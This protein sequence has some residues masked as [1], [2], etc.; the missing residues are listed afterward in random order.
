MVTIK[1][2]VLLSLA[3][4]L[5][6]SAAQ[7]AQEWKAGICPVMKGKTSPD[8][9]YEY[10]G[11]MYYFCCPGCIDAFKKDPRKYV[12]K[13]KEI[14]VTAKQYEFVPAKI[15]VKEGDIVRLTL[16]TADVRHGLMIHGYDVNIVVD[17]GESKTVE[18]LADKKGTF[19]FHCSV[20]C[21][22]GHKRMHGDLLVE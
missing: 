7:A 10:Q 21:G 5:L 9:S 6:V 15:T 11:K 14:A 12:S 4:L 22:S 16:T 1:R 17:K 13:I 18:F 2:T 3:V 8:Y 20:Y 19:H